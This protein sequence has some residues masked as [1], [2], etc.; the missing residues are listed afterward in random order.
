MS[1][2]AE[3]R[4]EVN[5][6]EYDTR[7]EQMAADG[8]NPHGEADFVCRYRPSTVLD[9]GCGT[10]RVAIELARRGIDVVGTDLDDDLLDRARHK[11]PELTWVTSNL[12]TLALGRTFDVVVLA[13]NI[14]IFIEPTDRAAAIERTGAHVGLGGRMIA[15]FQLR[16][17]GPTL[18]EFE[19]WSAA[20]G[21]VVEDRFAT[22]DGEPF[23]GGDY[24]VVVQRND[25]RRESS[26]P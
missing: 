11:A 17:T 4:Q 26:L 20:A 15:G 7:W 2:W 12:A 16:R 14:P 3:W 25:Q 21:L 9:A 1:N 22:W 13:G 19:K 6:D 24:V 5:L 23:S 8:Q 10:G 18:D